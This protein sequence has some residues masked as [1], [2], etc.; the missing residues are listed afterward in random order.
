MHQPTCVTPRRFLGHSKQYTLLLVIALLCLPA[1]VRRAPPAK[2]RSRRLRSLRHSVAG[3]TRKSSRRWMDQ[4]LATTR[5][6]QRRRITSPRNRCSAAGKCRP[7][8]RPSGLHP[9][10]RWAR[11][12]PT[13]VDSIGVQLHRMNQ[14]RGLSSSRAILFLC[15]T[16]TGR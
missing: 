11:R 9:S 16:E 15:C 7:R 2:R 14:A 3:Y 8:S 12:G 5:P 1:P 4:R 10:L 6:R 13:G